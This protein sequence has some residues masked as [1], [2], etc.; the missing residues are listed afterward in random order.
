MYD[1][2]MLAPA[3]V[4]EE[5]AAPLGNS[6]KA[7]LLLTTIVQIVSNGSLSQLWGMI[8]GMQIASYLPII[9]ISIGGIAGTLSAFIAGIVT[10]D[11]PGVDME[12]VLGS[13]FACPEED[14][15]LSN[16]G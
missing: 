5:F 4:K 8:N 2:G 15:I 3:E 14:A 12:S 13:W 9:N 16:L 1:Y 6:G 11:I 10:F 7:V